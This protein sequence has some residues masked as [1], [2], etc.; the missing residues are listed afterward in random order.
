MGLYCT[1]YNQSLRSLQQYTPAP[2]NYI[3]YTRY[4]S[5]RVANPLRGQLCTQTSVQL[6]YTSGTINHIPWAH[7]P[8]SAQAYVHTHA[9]LQIYT[10]ARANLSTRVHYVRRLGY[11]CQILYPSGTSTACEYKHAGHRAI[12]ASLR[13][14][15][16]NTV[17]YVRLPG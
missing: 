4:R 2:A 9:N 14:S 1:P 6:H 10:S 17:H 3:L 12:G 13:L 5:T 11:R 7:R 16:P 8:T 15:M